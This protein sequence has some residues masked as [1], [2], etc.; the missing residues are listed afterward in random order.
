MRVLAARRDGR[1]A[2]HRRRPGP[3][4]RRAR[5]PAAAPRLRSGG[6]RPRRGRADEGRPARDAEQFRA[7]QVHITKPGDRPD[8]PAVTSGGRGV[9]V[10]R[11]RRLS[12]PNPRPP[13][14]IPSSSPS[15]P[16]WRARPTA[17]RRCAPRPARWS[18]PAWTPGPPSGW[19]PPVPSGCGHWPPTPASRRS[20]AGPTPPARDLPHRPAARPRRRRRA[21]GARLAGADLPEVLP[22]QRQGSAGSGPPPVRVRRGELTSFEDEHSGRGGTRQ[23]DPAGGDRATTHRADARHRRH[24]PARPGRTRARAARRVH[25]RPGG[26][27]HRQDRRRPA[28]GGLPAV[29]ARRPAGRSGV[30][31]VGPNRAFLRYIERNCPPSARSTSTRP[32]CRPHRA[33][34]GPRGRRP[35]G[36]R[37]QGRCT[38]AEVLRRALQGAAQHL[39]HPRVALED[40]DL[41]VRPRGPGPGRSGRRPW[42]GRTSTSPS[43]GRTSRDVVQERPVRADDQ[44]AGPAQPLAVHVEQVGGP[45]QADGG[46]A[47]AGRALHADRLGERRRGR[48][49]PGRAG[50]WRRCRASGRR[51]GARSPSRRIRLRRARPRRGRGARPRSAVSSPSAKPNRRRG[52]HALRVDGAGPVERPGDRR[53][54]VDDHRVAGVVGDVP[55]ADVEGL[56]DPISGQ[57]VGAAEEGG[58]AGIRGQVPEPLGAGGTQPLGGPGVDTGVDHSRSPRYASPSGSRPRAPSGRARR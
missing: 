58:D 56:D 30:L 28:P 51:G 45:V 43:A 27:R 19:A 13:S 14:P 1:R 21:D 48:A 22:G 26:A 33:G 55:A 31:V 11:R 6:N 25:L 38:H 8:Q 49:R 24:H 4:R 12:L 53:P 39:G 32:P 40:G 44:H 47:G 15:A 37:P 36:R 35:Q 10:L 50:W 17:W 42:S 9:N 5:R 20:S 16:T 7:V 3:R 46:L 2:V 29:H 34:A 57:G 54:P 23:P 52:A 18:T 41:G